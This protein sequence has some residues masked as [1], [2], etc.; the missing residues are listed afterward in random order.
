MPEAVIVFGPPAGTVRVTVPSKSS[1]PMVALSVA[2]ILPEMTPATL[3]MV[4]SVTVAVAPNT[5]ASPL[6]VTVQFS[7][8]V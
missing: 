7:A 1:E 3:V 4:P 2:S 8:S 5:M 6:T